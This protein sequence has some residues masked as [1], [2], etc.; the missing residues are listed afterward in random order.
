MANTATDTREAARR[1]KQETKA[2]GQNAG[3]RVVS[4]NSLPKIIDELQRGLPYRRLTQFEKR[5]GLSQESIT[6]VIRVPKRT[7]ARRKA[8]GRLAPDESERLHRLSELFTKAVHLF[9]GD[10]DRA[11]RWLETPQRAL[12]KV[13]PL[14]MATTEVGAREVENLIG[15]LEHGVFT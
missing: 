15:R 3:F 6:R 8:S 7:L 12:G 13:T 5:T 11:R 1:G 2:T 4:S 10:P 9:A 14:E